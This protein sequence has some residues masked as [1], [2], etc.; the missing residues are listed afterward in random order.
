MNTRKIFLASL[1]TMVLAALLAVGVMAAPAVPGEHTLRQPDGQHFTATLHGDAFFN[2]AVSESGAVLEQTNNGTWVFAGTDVVYAGQAA[3]DEALS[4]RALVAQQEYR[5][6]PDVGEPLRFAAQPPQGRVQHTPGPFLGVEQNVLVLLVEFND[7]QIAFADDWGYQI[8]TGERSVAAWYYDISDGAIQLVPAPENQS[9]TDDGIVRVRLNRRHPNVGGNTST[10]NARITHDALRAAT[11]A[12]YI[13]PRDFD[14]NG[15]G[16][17]TNDELH[18]VVIVAG[19]EAA[20]GHTEQAVWGHYWNNAL[21]SMGAIGGLRFT[22]YSQV[23][24]RH[25]GLGN[26]HI[27]TIGIIV[28]ELGHSFGLPDLYGTGDFVGLGHYCVMG[29]GSWAH[30]PGQ[31]QGT[32]P[33]AFSAYALYRLGLAP[34]VHVPF[35]T[36]VETAVRSLCS[37]QRNLVRIEIPNND[38][39]FFLIENRQ[40]NGWDESLARISRTHAQGGL[41]VYRVDTRWRHNIHESQ[42]RVTMIEADEFIWGQSNLQNSVR[43][44]LDALFRVAPGRAAI[45]DRNSSPAWTAPGSWM[46]LEVLCESDPEMHITIQPVLTA[47]PDGAPL[48]VRH[49]TQVQMQTH[50][51]Q[52]NVTWRATGDIIVSNTG[53]VNTTQGRGAGTVTATDAAGNI[54]TIEVQGYLNWWQWLIWIF[55]LGFLWY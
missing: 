1:V 37:E 28:H 38:H 35:G 6:R 19:F 20:W 3:P 47:L 26:S 25:G 31:R 22:S 33:T 14:R 8:F 2:Y 40:F 12:G 36:N 39:Q 29:S 16:I 10:V 50:F 27:A 48:R 42:W 7:V 9:T 45:V 32:T 49:R 43:N 5:T 24:E 34:V 17:I 15:D 4:E 30:V 46:R 44:G 41:A 11:A 21:R 53:L 51:A 52:G 23:G 18:V 13:N 54:H 55:L